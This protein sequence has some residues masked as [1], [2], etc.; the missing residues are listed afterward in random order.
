MD[1]VLAQPVKALEDTGELDNTLIVL[2]SD[3][4]PEGA[5]LLSSMP[6]VTGFP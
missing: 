5:K 1:Y 2:T 4:G 3:N 6:M